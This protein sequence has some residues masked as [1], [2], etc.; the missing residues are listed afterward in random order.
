MNRIEVQLED[1][2]W[3]ACRLVKGIRE[4]CFV[5]E[6]PEVPDIPAEVFPVLEF[7]CD[8]VVS[9]LTETATTHNEIGKEST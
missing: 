8:R 1:R 5:L 4:I 7:A 9:L 3:E 2:V 6:T